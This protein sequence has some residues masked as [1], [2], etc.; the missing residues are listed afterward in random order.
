VGARPRNA[1][2]REI[3]PQAV[4]VRVRLLRRGDP[5][6]TR[7]L[8]CSGKSPK[9]IETNPS[10]QPEKFSEQLVMPPCGTRRSRKMGD[11]GKI[12]NAVALFSWQQPTPFDAMTSLGSIGFARRARLASL[13]ARA[14]LR[15]ARRLRS[16]RLASLGARVWFRLAKWLRP[17]RSQ[18][19]LLAR[20]ASF[21]AALLA[22]FGAW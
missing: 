2:A 21:G 7:V 20:S 9:V 19:A 16:A 22:W 4:A 14:W 3:R 10:A 15:L 11:L 5:R 1:R 12:L 13:G 18:S 17:A 6:T 8:L